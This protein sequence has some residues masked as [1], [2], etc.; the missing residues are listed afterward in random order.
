MGIIRERPLA[1]ALLM[2]GLPRALIEETG[3]LSMLL[4]DVEGILGPG[5]TPTLEDRSS[6]ET[7]ADLSGPFKSGI[8]ILKEK[9]M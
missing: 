7:N 4:V 5:R 2:T 9:T 1:D 6:N 8:L 3:E